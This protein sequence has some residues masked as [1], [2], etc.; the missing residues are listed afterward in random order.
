MPL[1]DKEVRLAKPGEKTQRLPDGRGMYLEI[2]PKG[3]KWWR[4]KYRFNKKEK[5]LAL[6]V[7]PDVSLKQAR[8]KR[9]DARRLL[10]EGIDPGEKRK[11]E[12]AAKV[13]ADAGSFESI[14]MEWYTRHY[15]NWSEAHSQRLLRLFQR[16]IFPWI[17]KT[18]ISE[19]TPPL[20]LTVLRRIENRGAVETAHRA[21]ANCGQVFRYA[22]ATGQV[23]RDP[24]A[25]LKGALPPVKPK[26]MATITEPSEIGVL[27][28]SIDGYQGTLIT[29]SALKLAPLCFVRPGELRHAEWSEINLD[30]AEWRIPEGKMKA[31]EQH[32]VPLSHQAI[33]IL[34]ELHPLTGIGEGKYVFPGTQSIHRPMSENT[35]L[36]ALRRMGYEKGE[37]TGH[38]F[39][40][41]ASTILNEQGWPSDV[42][43]RQL[44]HAERNQVRAAY[45]HAQHLPERK[46]MMQS[47]ADYLD[48]L[49]KGGKVISLKAPA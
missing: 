33:A 1:T 38:G 8:T 39:R 44:A 48:A 27:L 11:I 10:T 26:R 36:A 19:I 6:G 23:E 15:H 45:N 35:V 20:L 7:Y 34:E 4:L 32:I 9:E 2:S 40:A 30:K 24:T 12:K 49:K 47:W 31:R 5:R 46:K 37:M 41:M 3:G 29:K 16:D 22:V 21:R 13:A 18:L 28:R 43:E 17:G 25:D 42:I 14:T